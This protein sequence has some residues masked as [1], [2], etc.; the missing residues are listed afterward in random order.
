MQIRTAVALSL[1]VAASACAR[2][3][4]PLARVRTARGT[5]DVALE[6]ADTPATR[7]RGLMYR[8][9]LPDG[10]GMLFVFDDDADHEFWMKNTL[11]PLDM[12]FIAAD[13][14]IVG[15]RADA[16]PLSTAAI[17]VG[18]ASRFVLEVPGGW[19]GRHGVAAGDRVELVGVR[20]P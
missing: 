9:A 13:G 14:R 12:L 17:G 15:I 5:A 19:A 2:D 18:A 8:N 11:I 1:L 20:T 10:S 16:T 6:V 3:A 7:S 4:G